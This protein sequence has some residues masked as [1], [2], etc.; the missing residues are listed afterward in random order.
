MYRG[1][2]GD[3]HRIEKVRENPLEGRPE[4]EQNV[5]IR[6]PHTDV[7]VQALGII[8]PGWVAG[9]APAASPQLPGPGMNMGIFQDFHTTLWILVLA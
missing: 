9:S 6:C 1:V 5:H 3:A 8:A 2:S 7:G 4:Q